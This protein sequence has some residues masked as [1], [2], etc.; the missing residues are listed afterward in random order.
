MAE[1]QTRVVVAG[2]TG[3]LGGNVVQALHQHGY[4]VRAL[5]RDPHK[6]SRQGCLLR[7]R[8]RG[9]RH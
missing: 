1:A 7:R 2:A 4:W 6:L 3:Y 9:L 5:A 8:F